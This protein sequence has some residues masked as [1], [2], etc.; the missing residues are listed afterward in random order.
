MA[1]L[2][3]VSWRA[4]GYSALGTV[5]AAASVVAVVNSD[6]V[7]PLSLTSN[8]ATRWLVDQIND[9]LVLVDGLA[10]RVVARIETDSVAGDQVA[11]Q[12][13]GGAFLVAKGEG[14]LRTISTAKLALGTT[15]AVGLLL[16]AGA[17]FG[18]GASG[19]TI[20]SPDTDQASVVA[21]DDASRPIQIPPADKSLVAADGSMWLLN[22]AE[23]THVNVDETH[24]T[25]P[26]RST[27]SQTITI[28]AH[29]VVYDDK[30]NTVR[31][32]DGG[33]VSI[34][35]IPNASEAV[36]QESGDDASCVWLGAGDRLVCVGKT[37]IDHTLRISGMNIKAGDRLAVAGTA[38]VFVGEGNDV[39]RIDLQNRVLAADPRPDVR[40]GASRLKITASGNLI[41]LDDEAGARAWVVHQ[42]GI[43]PINKA[44]DTAPLLDAQGQVTTEG[45]VG[46]GPSTGG[47]TSPGDDET[48]HRDDNGHDDPPT[49]V[50]D[51]VTARSGSTV[52]I[53]VT[54]NDYDP[55]GDAIAVSAVGTLKNAGNGTTDVLNGTSVVYVPNPGFSGSDSFDYTIVDENGGTSTATVD[56]QLFPPGTPNQAPIARSD[57]VKT[58]I[59]KAVTI[60]VLANDIDPER[61]PLTISSFRQNG[62]KITA[63]I[64][65]SGLPALKYQPTGD[66]ADTYTFTY[67]SADPQGS[68]SQKTVVTV[69]V[70]DAANSAPFANPDAIRLPVGVAD[71]LDVMANDVDPDGDDLT[72][73]GVDAPDG[74]KA[75]KKGQQLR[76]TLGPG[77]K[78]LSVVKYTLSDGYPTHDT[79]GKVLVLKIGDTAPNRPPVANPD[80]E[81]VVIGASVKIPV[82]ANDIDPD[83]DAIRLLTVGKPEGG[84][85]ITTVENDSVRFT[86]TLP[87]ITEPTP[88][89]FL[90]TITDGNGHEVTGKVTVTVLVEALPSAPFARDDFADTVTDKSVN[91][92]VLAND[93]DPSGGKPSL[94][95]NPA[96]PGGGTA[97]RTTD[98]R[99]TFDP[100]AG[101]TGTFRCSYTV[102]SIQGLLADALIIVSVTE[103][104]AG[105]RDPVITEG[106]TQ[107][108]VNLGSS[109]PISANDIATDAD[110]D[111]LVF[112]SVGKPQD[113]SV[114]FTPGSSTLVYQA[115]APGS[116]DKTPDATDFD[117]TISDGNDGIVRGRL[118][119]KIL[120]VA[121]PDSPAVKPSTYEIQVSGLA[122]EPVIVDV[123]NLLTDRNFGTTLTLTG[124][125]VDSGPA[126][127]PLI[128]NGAVANIP[129]TGPGPGTVVVTY[130]V[131]NTAGVAASDKI[132]I[133]LT[134]PP[135]NEPPVAVNDAMTISSGGSNTVDLLANDSGLSDPGDN[136]QVSLKNRP[137]ASF[138]TV[139]LATTGVLTFVAAPQGFGS[140]VLTYV[141]SDGSG[142]TDEATVTLNLQQCGESPPSAR[143]GNLFTP[144]M[145]PINVDLTALVD[146]GT[147]VASSVSGAGLTAP[148]GV[149][150]PPAGMN[151]TETVTFT[152]VNGCRETHLAQLI[153]DVNHSPIGGSVDR[154]ASAGG[155]PIT[156]SVNELAS[157]E[158]ALTI[159]GI[160]PPRGWVTSDGTTITI[161]PPRSV[162]GAQTFTVTVQDPGGLTATAAIN[163]NVTNLGPNANA[164]EYFPDDPSFVFDPTLNDTD[165]EG[166]ALTIQ[167]YSSPSNGS[168]LLSVVDNTFRIQLQ[169]GVTTLSYTIHDEGGL[170]DSSTITITL[171]P[172]PPAN[173]APIV[174]DV[175]QTVSG[176]ENSVHFSIMVT[177]LD[178]DAVTLK[179]A[180]P[181][182]FIVFVTDDP[183][184]SQGPTRTSFNLDIGLPTGWSSPATITCTAKDSAGAEGTGTVTLTQD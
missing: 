102:S 10:G 156:V 88:V 123:V 30:N 176:G 83:H 8:A 184:G 92:D 125:T 159:I 68:T 168:T 24:S 94:T 116:A 89:T 76:I 150:T 175:N 17:I 183:G 91:I 98:N 38:A 56:V 1:Q 66:R 179:C 101:L 119:I 55:D 133:N 138:G 45:Q 167:T 107:K 124:A 69:E 152:V 155:T 74:V 72:I 65:P 132:R 73:T 151:G 33:D 127:T 130:T 26:L 153:I 135:Q 63:D 141:L 162:N 70:T 50:D 2:Q 146:S 15:Q 16:D 79:I 174:P 87:D 40:A 58:G 13:P 142:A 110:G 166:G 126:G 112:S 29:A 129:T 44:D 61:D 97:T 84:G 181:S 120:D 12:G 131:T 4:V 82:T 164:D 160:D 22:S 111:A 23:A 121:P 108:Q 67:Q 109:L 11:V 182:G 9:R 139:D 118:S 86:P 64:G 46:S 122:G 80:T 39:R 169:P 103:A 51:S 90:Y 95:G 34:A 149:Y 6:G 21:V 145:T 148:T 47:G 41:W 59:G 165:P 157:D 178:G 18:V 77:A 134:P 106:A 172:P 54:R 75:E 19:L 3:K 52:T 144:Y 7:R 49:A 31:W 99:V 62:A 25:V 96:C 113:G 71:N 173:R 100:P 81:R 161:A 93:S 115:P 171:T 105:N 158:E 14:S 177:D 170:T 42:F 48:D 37:G 154:S 85:G 114:T 140:V 117:F 27:P 137:P 20:L 60:D 163:V 43:N 104:P 28:G 143:N 35:S 128:L 53:P 57:H 180:G 36:L 32:L 136:V 147:I 78:E 5:L